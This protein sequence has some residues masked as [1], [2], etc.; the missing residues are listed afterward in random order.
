[1]IKTYK[2]IPLKHI[3]MGNR[4]LTLDKFQTQKFDDDDD[5]LV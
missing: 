5:S 3:Q 4:S 2:T 1:M